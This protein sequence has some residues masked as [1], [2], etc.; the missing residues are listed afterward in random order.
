MLVQR[1][2][3]KPMVSNSSP[4]GAPQMQTAAPPAVPATQLLVYAL[5]RPPPYKPTRLDVD[6]LTP[7]RCNHRCRQSAGEEPRVLSS[8][9]CIEEVGWSLGLEMVVLLGSLED[10]W[11]LFL[12]GR[13]DHLQSK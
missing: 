4:E 7:C 13:E 5:L 3:A 11:L 12:D 9:I 6:L 2:W 8:K 1:T 10:K